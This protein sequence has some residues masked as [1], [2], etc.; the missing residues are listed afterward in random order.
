LPSSSGTAV[1]IES[2][3]AKFADNIRELKSP[4]TKEATLRVQYLDPLFKLLGWD[5][6]N[7]AGSPLDE[8]DVVI[9][10]SIE[11]AE[12]DRLR[13]RR[14]DYLFRIGGHAELTCEAKKPAIDIDRDLEAIFQA[15][16]DAYSLGLPFAILTDFEHF[17]L[18]DTGYQP[19]IASP[20]HG[21]VSDFS[22]GF[23]DYPI[24]WDVLLATLGREAVARGSLDALRARV[25]RTRAG[26][27]VRRIDRQLFELRGDVPA[28]DAFL[29]Q[30]EAQRH[31]I[32]ADI[33]ANN[34]TT[35]ADV[36]TPRG[37][38][39]LAEYT[40]R[41]L[42]RVVFMRI[43]EDRNVVNY[44]ILRD[45]VAEAEDQNR[46]LRDLLVRQFRQY[47]R[48][49]N[50]YLFKHHDLE[51]CE[52]TP[53]VLRDLIAQFYPPESRTNFAV[54][55]DDLLATVYERFLGSAITVNRGRVEIDQKPE[56]RHNDGVYYTPKFVV[57][58]ICRRVVAP[59]IQDKKPVE[60]LNSNLTILDPACGSGSFLVTAFD[61]LVKHCERAITAEPALAKVSVPGSRRRQPIAFQQ[62][63][64]LATNAA[65]QP[66]RTDK[67]W[68]LTPDFKGRLLTDCIFGVDIDQQ[69]VEVTI[70][71]LYSKVL[72]N[73]PP[74]WRRIS[75][76]YILPP[77]DN[78]IRCGN[79]LI[80]QDR[81]DQFA[82]ERHGRLFA[83]DD[84]VRFRINAF[85][86]HSQTRGFGRI[87]GD[88]AD[89][90]KGFDC[91]IG[92]PPYIRVQILNQW[93]PEECEFYKWQYVS[94]ARGNY[95]IYVAFTERVLT[96]GR[97]GRGLLRENGRMGFIMP[98]KWWQATYGE[99]L[100]HIVASAHFLE[101][102][103]DFGEF[104]VFRGVT[105]YTAIHI[106]ARRPDAIEAV[107]VARIDE[108]DDGEF[109]LSAIDNG[110]AP[111]GTRR[112]T[113]TVPQN[114]AWNIVS[115]A[116]VVVV[117]RTQR[118]EDV[119]RL[120][121]G[122]KTSADKIYIGQVSTVDD[123]LVLFESRAKA[124]TYRIE[125]TVLRPLVKSEHM[126]PYLPSRT[127]LALLFPY[128]VGDDEWRL[129]SQA[130]F[131]A[132]APHAWQ[133]LLQVRSDL[134]GRESGRMAQRDDWYAYIYPKNFI[135]LSQPKLM[136]PD[137]CETLH[138]AVDSTGELIFSGGAAGGNAIIPHDPANLLLLS[139]L[140]NSRLLDTIKR[141]SGT[142]FRGGWLNC[143]IRFIRDLPIKLPSSAAEKAIAERIEVSV[144]EILDAQRRLAS[145][146]GGDRD[147]RDLEAAIETANNRINTAVMQLYNVDHIP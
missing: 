59:K 22:L 48:D 95:D 105:T 127:E 125:R 6:S 47:D 31:H 108:M 70:M 32:A 65:G 11:V 96:G 110:E 129:M 131:Q 3:V 44:G 124:Q 126:R 128:R 60:L 111:P 117:E 144:R 107:D 57:D 132:H 19:D 82:E 93:A 40:Q 18:Y 37:A 46:Q 25:R 101:G 62:T 135:A 120:A 41:L 12:R 97:E 85:D 118:L 42:D 34:R 36:A 112:F 77:L 86:W 100:R 9:E 73:L 133:Y 81:L 72:N 29:A 20:R 90:N 26:Q 98:H 64:V 87:L 8:Q 33:Y 137:M 15:K 115:S 53:S 21:L 122:L 119:A 55:P 10:P 50:G 74:D 28:G 43:C 88:R 114:G 38:A 104:Q 5:V 2:L 30:L 54:L 113:W 91:V 14:P 80:D 1:T 66:T 140:L 58:S 143:E 116:D 7:D 83:G 63:I 39:R 99:S 16:R 102:L 17:R 76:S 145:G 139:G 78:N 61:M 94:A 138:V 109:T 69:A 142:R 136:I 23:A 89:T 71:S 134:E 79:S 103:V 4:A 123:G 141:S 51:T 130:E 147:R 45:L 52:F 121:Q 24:Q 106:F 75:E 92:N 27:R 35:F 84:N 13:A 67:I 49:F 68:R 146:I 56:V